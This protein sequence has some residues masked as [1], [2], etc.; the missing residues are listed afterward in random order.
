MVALIVLVSFL[1][2]ADKHVLHTRGRF[3]LLGHLVAFASVGFM[4]V[5]TPRTFRSRIL[6]VAGLV[7]LA[8]GIEFGEHLAFSTVIEWPDVLMDFMGVFSGVVLALLSRPQTDFSKR[9]RRR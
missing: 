7:L 1:P 8:F 5:M 2:P 4:A 3:H 6:F 9:S